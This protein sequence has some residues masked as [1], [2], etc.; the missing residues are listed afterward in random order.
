VDKAMLLGTWIRRFLLEHLV[1]ERNLAPNTQRSYRDTLVLLIP[2]VAK[3]A[4]KAVDHLSVV[5]MSA[6]SGPI[7]IL[8]LGQIRFKNRLEHDDCCHLC[9]AISYRRNA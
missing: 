1:A 8:L 2:F 9:H 4:G 7:G 5:D 3:K 6:S